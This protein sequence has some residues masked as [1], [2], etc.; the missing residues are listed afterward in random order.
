MTAA[1]PLAIALFRPPAYLQTELEQR[2][3]LVELAA[4]GPDGAD[5]WLETNGR[6]VSAV[7]TNGNVGCGR[8]LVEALPNLGIIAIYGVGY[9]KVDVGAARSRGIVVANTPGVLT[10]DVAD[11]AVG[12]TI[13]LLRGIARADRFI[14]DGCW[15]RAS[16]P[17]ETKVTGKRFGIIG[18]GRIGNA[19]ADRLS[20]FG[21]VLYAGTRAKDVPWAFHDNVLSLAASSD[22]LIVACAATGRTRGLVS[23]EVLGALGPDG[24][25]VNIARGSIVDEA[26]LVHAVQSE[27]IAG[28]ALDVFEDEP[29]VRAELT[30]SERVLL[31]P[32]IGSATRQ[33][34][35]AMADSLLANLDAFFAGTAVPHEVL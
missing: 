33:T 4:L 28:A 25:L 9:D 34:R 6:S 23:E 20:T 21:P 2:F 32:H 19:I 29:N 5:R 15:S 10:D 11:L 14:R 26:A 22:V 35:R 13:C 30:A 12:L 17:P 1:K 31:T 16:Y 24:Y 8:A 27:G 7:I 3:E 18:L